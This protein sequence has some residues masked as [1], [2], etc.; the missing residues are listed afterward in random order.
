MANALKRYPRK[1]HHKREARN[2]HIPQ[3]TFKGRLLHAQNHVM[4]FRKKHFFSWGDRDNRV[5]G[6]AGTNTRFRWRCHVGFG[7]AY[8][9]VLLQLGLA[10]NAA[11][12]DPAVNVIVTPAGGAALPTETVHYGLGTGTP[13]D[14]PN[15]MATFTVKVPVTPNTTYECVIQQVDYARIM[16]VAAYEEPRPLI[17]TSVDFYVDEATTS[18]GF[19][20]FDQH[21]QDHLEGLSK[22]WRRNGGHIYSY[23]GPD[24][25]TVA[26]TT[27]TNYLDA[28]TAGVTASSAKLR[29]GMLA[30]SEAACRSSDGVTLDVVLAVYAQATGGN[31][32]EVRFQS[33]GGTGCSITGVTTVLQW[34]TTTTT[35]SA[36]EFSEVDLQFRV[37]NAAHSMQ[38]YAVSLYC[39]LT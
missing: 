30:L 24:S 16:S 14:A 3:A 26:S 11:A 4:G 36:E 34:H 12:A 20:I 25:P 28:S 37:S 7:T 8:I 38:L 2:S 32:G 1:I 35:I 27:W 6:A 17:D 22:I 31:T 9:T 13:T 19:P 21:R 10:D 29:L 39:Y 23:A 18:V 5:T 15:E 33:V